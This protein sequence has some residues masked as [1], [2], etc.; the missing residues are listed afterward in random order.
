MVIGAVHLIVINGKDRVEV[1]IRTALQHKWAEIY[2]K[3][4]DQAGRGPRYGSVPDVPLV[5]RIYELMMTLSQLIASL[6]ERVVHRHNLELML[7]DITEADQRGN[8]EAEIALLYDTHEEI[9]ASIRA[10]LDG[11]HELIVQVEAL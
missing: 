6:E 9:E 7:C 4:A 11:T 1:Q 5:Q 2:E 3:F 8:V 10:A